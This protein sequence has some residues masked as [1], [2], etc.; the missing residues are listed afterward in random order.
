MSEFNTNPI[1]SGPYKINNII[2]ESNVP[3]EYNL[4][5][6]RRY[7]SGR[8]FINNLNIFIYQNTEDLLKALNNNTIEG[9]HI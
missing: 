2:K 7:I 5:S 9:L 8:P 4:I 6:N 3:K 1:G